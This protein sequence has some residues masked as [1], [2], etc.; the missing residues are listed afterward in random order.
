MDSLDA[1]GHTSGSEEPILNDAEKKI[2][3]WDSYSFSNMNYL[4]SLFDSR[5]IWSF[6]SDHTFLVLNSNGDTYSV[7]FSI[8]NPLFDISNAML[9]LFE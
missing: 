7:Y 2:P 8:E 4:N 6:I 9:V 5:N 3:S 1:L